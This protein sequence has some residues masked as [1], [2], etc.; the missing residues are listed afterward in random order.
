MGGKRITQA[1][2]IRRAHAVHG[3]RYDYSQAVFVKSAFTCHHH[4]S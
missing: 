3:D 2:F 1:E 4:L